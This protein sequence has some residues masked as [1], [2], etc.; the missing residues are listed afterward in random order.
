MI[1]LKNQRL[2]VI[3]PHPDDEV[4]GCAGLIQK[5]KEQKGKVFVLFLTVADTKDF[6]RKGYSSLENRKS[7][8]EKVAKLLKFDKADIAL[9]GKGFHLKLDVLGQERLM[10]II[11]R[12]SSLSLEKINPTMVVFPSFTSYN[13]DHR[14]TALAVHAALRPAAKKTKHFV[15]CV[16]SFEEPADLWSTSFQNVP[17]V[18]IPLTR[19]EVNIKLEAMKLYRSQMRGFPNMRSVKTLETL[20]ILRGSM[21]GEAYA[22]AYTS[23]RLT[24]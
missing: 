16:L 5:V 8:I 18:F 21:I 2:L 22:E 10:N 13:Q 12:E 15:P 17:T 24:M 19:K 6:S 11:E 4:I 3:A 1:C 23:Y 7:E 9:E 14:V 20:A